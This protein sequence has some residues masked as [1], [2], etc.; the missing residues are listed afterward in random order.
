M[1]IVFILADIREESIY[2]LLASLAIEKQNRDHAAHSYRPSSRTHEHQDDARG[3][4]KLS[5]ASRRLILPANPIAQT[6]LIVVG[7]A[8][9]SRKYIRAASGV[10]RG[11]R[12]AR[13]TCWASTLFTGEV[14]PLHSLVSKW[15]T[16]G[17]HRTKKAQQT[18]PFFFVVR[19]GGFEPH[20]LAIASPSGWSR[21]CIGVNRRV[22]TGRMLGRS[23]LEHTP[24]LG[25]SLYKPAPHE[26]VCLLARASAN[27]KSPSRSAW[28]ASSPAGNN[29]Y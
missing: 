16:T 12:L 8:S 24:L 19:K 26:M 10:P 27:M 3:V 29:Y 2:T 20:D 4:I 25:L 1:E 13:A 17:G 6:T 28:A 22:F 5:R 11:Q 23:V 21:T 18:G 7:P 14:G 15:L 9:V